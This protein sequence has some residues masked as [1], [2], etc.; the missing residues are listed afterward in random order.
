VRRRPSRAARVCVWIV[1]G[2][3][4]LAALP[5]HAAKDPLRSWNDGPVKHAIVTFVANTTRPGSPTF[6]PAA[7]RIATFDNDGTLWAEQPL[8]FQFLFALDRVKALAPQHPEWKDKPPFKAVLE[9]DLKTALAGGEPAIVDIV[10]ATHSGTTTDEFTKI[11]PDWIAT[12]R[13]SRFGR[14]FSSSCSPISARA[15]SR[16][17]ASRA[18][19]STSCASGRSGARFIGIVHHTDAEREWAYDRASDVGRL[20]KALDEGTARGWT[21]VDMKRDWK[22]VFPFEAK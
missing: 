11:V 22:R 13:H 12:A 20:D 1:T 15:A 16:R 7:D 14:P 2:E 4:L 5:A 3:L 18:A 17:S 9:N 21:I 8:Y 10:M 6:V 19:A